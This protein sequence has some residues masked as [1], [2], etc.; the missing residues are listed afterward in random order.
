[1]A[2]ATTAKVALIG[3]LIPFLYGP[4]VDLTA[5]NVIIQAA[6]D[7]ASAWMTVYLDA[8]Y[9]GTTAVETAVQTR[10]EAYIALSYLTPTL[11]AMKV[12]G[13]HAPLD[14]E[15]GDSYERLLEQ[16]WEG[17]AKSLLQKWIVV[18]ITGTPSGATPFALPYFSA[19]SPVDSTLRD[20]EEIQI[21]AI[22]DEA[23]GRVELV[24]ETVT[25]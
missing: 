14:S 17:L 3:G 2:L 12:Y 22:D 1:M 16:D 9:G 21:S 11:R 7:D 13:T 10:A 6:I 23:R 5:M 15:E 18:E 4:D 8:A 25:A 19:T 24:Q 20:V